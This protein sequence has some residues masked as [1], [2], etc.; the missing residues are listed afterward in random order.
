VN[1]VFT[2]YAQNFEDLMLHRAL[3]SVERGFYIDI[4]AQHPEI[5]SVSQAFYERGWSGVH[6]EPVAGYAAML[7]EA[8]TGDVVIEAAVSNE[9]G[10]VTL[11]VF[12]ETGLSTVVE[13][14]A[15]AH[16]S[17]GGGATMREVMVPAITLAMLADEIGEREVHW[18]KIDVEGHEKA[19]LEG[20][21][22]S[23]L[24]P[25]ICLIEATAPNSMVSNHEAWEHLLLE[26]EY[27][28]VYSDGLNRFYVAS[29]KAALLRPAFEVPPNVFDEFQLGEHVGMC[30][31]LV[32][33]HER[34]L[35]AQRKHYEAELLDL[36][37]SHHQM[38]KDFTHRLHTM[39][40]HLNAANQ[41]LT[42]S[43]AANFAVRSSLSWRLT[44]PLRKLVDLLVRLKGAVSS[45]TSPAAPAPSCANARPTRSPATTAWLARLD[46]HADRA[47]P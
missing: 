40:L 25:W 47:D 18:L 5:D 36:S 2:S 35:S 42:T 31:E 27:E 15:T 37:E 33:R 10:E 8:R 7:R 24:R 43:E 22:P 39:Q 14:V 1:T 32:V 41:A 38:V 34:R 11:A 26:A 3:A 20:W 45:V 30:R 29:E 4:G 19:V 16:V 46:Q 28:H 6:V 21:D 23:R 9:A 13:G 17:E 12:P 44:A